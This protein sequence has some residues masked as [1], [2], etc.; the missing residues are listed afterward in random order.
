[1]R[2]K[3]CIFYKIHLTIL[4]LIM[5]KVIKQLST[6]DNLMKFAECDKAEKSVRNV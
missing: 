5:I 4:C 1:M 6:P 3:N 2:S